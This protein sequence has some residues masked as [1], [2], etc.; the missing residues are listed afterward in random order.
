LSSPWTKYLVIGAVHLVFAWGGVHLAQ[1]QKIGVTGQIGISSETDSNH[2]KDNSNVVIWLEPLTPAKSLRA[3]FPE[4]EQ[5]RH[6]QLVQKN[7]QFEPHLLVV[8]VG[9]V[10]RFPNQDVLFHSVFS[11]FNNKRFDLGLYEAG[12]EKEVAFNTPGISYIFCNIHAHMSAAVITL[13]TPYFAVSNGK[14]DFVISD[15]PAGEYTLNIWAEGASVDFLNSMRKN[16]TVS[17]GSFNLGTFELKLSRLATEHKNKYD[18]LY[19]PASATSSY[20]QR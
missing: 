13:E 11:M 5:N 6:F 2:R 18:S 16:V 7:K 8:P 4:I 17:A 19:D 12:T 1:A 14:G 9:A 20:S 3:Y 15:V 10:V